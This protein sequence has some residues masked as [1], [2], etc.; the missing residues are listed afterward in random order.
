MNYN[1]SQQQIFDEMG[2][3][4]PYSVGFNKSLA[5]GRDAVTLTTPPP[6]HV[7]LN[8]PPPI[9]QTTPNLSDV[10]TKSGLPTVGPNYSQSQQ[11]IIIVPQTVQQA[12]APTPCPEC[13]V[14]A[15]CP[16]PEVKQNP[17]N[18]TDDQMNRTLFDILATKPVDISCAC[19]AFDYYSMTDPLEGEFKWKSEM[20][21]VY[22]HQPKIT[23]DNILEIMNTPN[24]NQWKS[25][26]ELKVK[27]SRWSPEPPPHRAAARPN[28]CD[29]RQ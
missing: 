19:E 10:L 13:P 29:K 14:C 7:V 9:L 12:P 24:S 17:K 23:P 3:S 28:R 15:S 16:E 2:K 21:F 26:K 18:L 22:R 27:Y 8:S 1:I 6:K 25:S 11:P 4:V 5:G 20:D